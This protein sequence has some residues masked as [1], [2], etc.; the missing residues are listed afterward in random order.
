MHHHTHLVTVSGV[1][2]LVA[3]VLCAQCI[4]TAGLVRQGHVSSPSLSLQ[5]MNEN[6]A[7]ADADSTAHPSSETPAATNYF[8]QY[9]SSR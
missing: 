7:V 4:L 5:L 1:A 2:M 8:L 6:A 3:D 9:I